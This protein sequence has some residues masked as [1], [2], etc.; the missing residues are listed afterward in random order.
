MFR[1]YPL[2]LLCVLWLAGCGA[3]EERAPASPPADTVAVAP[4]E[5]PAAPGAD[6]DRLTILFLG[7][8]LSAGYGL[9]PDQAFPALIQQKIDSLGWPFRVVNAGLSGETTAGGLRRIDWLLRQ[10]V[11]VL[12]IELGGNDGLR[13]TPPE[14]TK[15]NLQAIIDRTRARYP[16]VRIVLAGMQVP[17]N[18]G[19]EYTERFRELFPELARENDVALIPFLLEG[20]GGVPALNLPDGIHPT[21]EGHRIVAE[22]VWRTLRPL[23]ASMLEA[24]S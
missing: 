23:L 3:G 15:A 17:P 24:T 18:L 14:V 12:V 1:L 8:S 10:K 19:A 6:D 2:P 11:D 4:P 13:G 5:A 22:T 16:D 9:D 21:A 20:V 7:N